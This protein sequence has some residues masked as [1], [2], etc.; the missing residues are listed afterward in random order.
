MHMDIYWLGHGC[1]R[2]R[3]S[4]ATVITDPAAPSTGYKI[5]K[6]PAEIVTL[7][8]EDP[9]SSYLQAIQGEPKVLRS[10]GE[11]EIAG[12]MMN[13]VPTPPDPKA[14][15]VRNTAFVFEMDDVRIVHL[16]NIAQIPH[17]DDVET[18]GGADVLIVPIGGGMVL[19]V[20]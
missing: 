15:Q 18:M 19:D 6:L 9:Q 1:F 20:A 7:S 2:L 10:P 14:P 13:G 4:E 17:A 16:G 11:Y 3:G 8:S 5:G 12:V